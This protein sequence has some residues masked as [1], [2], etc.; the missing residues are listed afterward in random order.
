[1]KVRFRYLTPTN[2]QRR[3]QHLQIKQLV[4]EINLLAFKIVLLVCDTDVKAVTF[5]ARDQ[6]FESSHGKSY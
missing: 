1:M 3:G 4:Q 6:K 2:S 5:D